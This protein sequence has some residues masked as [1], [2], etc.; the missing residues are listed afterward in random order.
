[1]ITFK[2]F[3]IIFMHYIKLS[4]SFPFSSTDRFKCDNPT[5]D[6]TENTFVNIYLEFDLKRQ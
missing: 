2:P 3:L 1:M 6:V 5:L 4:G